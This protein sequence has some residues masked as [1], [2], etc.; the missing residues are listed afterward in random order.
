[1]DTTQERNGVIIYIAAKSKQFAIYGD[2]GINDKVAN[3]FGTQQKTLCSIILKM[4][5]I[6]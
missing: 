1:M 6:N 4:E 3:D 5:K 2:K